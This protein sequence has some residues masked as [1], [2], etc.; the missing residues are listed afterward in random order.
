VVL[1]DVVIIFRRLVREGWTRYHWESRPCRRPLVLTYRRKLLV[2]DLC[3]LTVAA[4]YFIIKLYSTV[5]RQRRSWVGVITRAYAESEG[6]AGETCEGRGESFRLDYLVLMRVVIARMPRLTQM[7][8]LFGS[9]GCRP[10]AGGLWG[11]SL[12]RRTKH[13]WSS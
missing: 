2:C 12:R 13:V 1:S 3:P 10:A 9:T 6:G 8:S 4:S 7:D 11:T 5:R